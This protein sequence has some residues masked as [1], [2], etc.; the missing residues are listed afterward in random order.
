ML[1]RRFLAD[2]RAATAI[3]YGL[4]AAMLAVTAIAG[5][6]MFGGGLSGLFNSVSAR[7]ANAMS[8]G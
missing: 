3:E 2:E 4:I 5:M 7:S 6:T 1:L 8:G